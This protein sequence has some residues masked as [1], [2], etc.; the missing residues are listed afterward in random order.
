MIWDCSVLKS[1][2]VSFIN[3]IIFVNYLLIFCILNFGFDLSF[4][5][6]VFCFIFVFILLFLFLSLLLFFLLF[7]YIY[8]VLFLLSFFFIWCL[9]TCSSFVN[10]CTAIIW[11]AGYKLVIVAGIRTAIISKLKFKFALPLIQQN[12]SFSI[13]DLLMNDIILISFCKPFRSLL[14]PV[15]INIG[16]HNMTS[17]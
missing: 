16:I 5:L 8:F 17:E 10:D 13:T 1:I 12:C 11:Y 14:C 7:F 9:W 6:F 2:C 15:K 4:I 3:I